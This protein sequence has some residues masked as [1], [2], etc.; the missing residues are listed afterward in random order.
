MSVD[1]N[2]YGRVNSPAVVP[3]NQQDSTV[4]SKTYIGENPF[5]AGDILHYQFHYSMS[6]PMFFKVTRVSPKCVWVVE[7]GKTI[8][9]NRDGY[10]QE[11]TEIPDESAIWSKE[12]RCALRESW[13]GVGALVDSYSGYVATLWDGKPKEFWGD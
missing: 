7:L 2:G 8:A 13:R 3:V 6:F 12:K 5:K 10:G 9:E 4:M 1:S 11:G